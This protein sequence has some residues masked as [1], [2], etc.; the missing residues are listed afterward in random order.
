[1]MARATSCSSKSSRA[2]GRRRP[3]G[4]RRRC[5]EASLERQE[6]LRAIVDE[7][8]LRH[9]TASSA[10]SRL[11]ASRALVASGR[12][13]ARVIRGRW[14]RAR[15]LLPASRSAP[16]PEGLGPRRPPASWM[17]RSPRAPSEFAPDTNTP[18]Q[19]W[20]KTSAADSNRTSIDGSEKFTGSST[21]GKV[22]TWVDEQVV[23][24]R[25]HIHGPGHERLL[26][27]RLAPRQPARP[28]R[29]PASALGLC[30]GR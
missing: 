22:G 2:P 6:I 26:I 29:A 3:S 20:P 5:A 28:A 17:A 30:R 10:R 1:M 9:F 18:A 21:E 25:R 11:P 7:E 16:P 27:H 23:V 12:F 19:R 8:E 13:P 24:R 15:V 4:V 14:G